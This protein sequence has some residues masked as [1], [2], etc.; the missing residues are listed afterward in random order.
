MPVGD[1]EM[2]A[3]VENM[4]KGSRGHKYKLNPHCLVSLSPIPPRC[5]RHIC[6]L[7]NKDDRGATFKCNTRPSLQN[8]RAYLGH[9][10]LGRA[11]KPQKIPLFANCGRRHPVEKLGPQA[12]E[13]AKCRPLARPSFRVFVCSPYDL[14][15][16]SKAIS[17]PTVHCFIKG[18]CV[19]GA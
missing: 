17:N 5:G 18:A 7:S 4:E 10:N 9:G 14:A 8:K 16:K 11:T 1:E 6:W 12:R 13:S 3:F 15:L 2:P 19:I